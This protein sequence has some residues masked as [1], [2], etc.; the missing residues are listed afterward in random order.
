MIETDL[1]KCGIKLP[2]DRVLGEG[3]FVSNA[4]TFKNG[5]SPINAHSGCQ[6]ACHTDDERERRVREIGINAISQAIAVAK[7]DRARKAKTR[8]GGHTVHNP[9]GLVDHHRPTPDKDSH[10][11]WHG[12]FVC[13]R[14]EPLQGQVIIMTPGRTQLPFQYPDARHTLFNDVLVAGLQGIHDPPVREVVDYCASLQPGRQPVTFGFRE[15]ERKLS[16]DSRS[17][18]RI[19][20]ALLFSVCT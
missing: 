11:G 10:C 5:V 4:V 14:N 8:H 20:L 13:V 6:P 17:R 18:P 9:G 2:F 7:A 12:P 3:I 19:L 15:G 1:K 16:A